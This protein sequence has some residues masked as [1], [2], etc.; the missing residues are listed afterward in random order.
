[1][2][3]CL[4]CEIASGN[5]AGDILYEDEQVVAF[6]DINPKAP[7]HILVIPRRHISTINDL[8][9]GDE[10]VIGKLFTAAKFLAENENIA[11]GGYRV[12]MNCNADGGQ[13][14]YHIHLHL[15]GGRPMLWP[16][17]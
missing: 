11:D 14:V 2:S 4:F 17:G 9:D 8:S 12:V 3:S 16:P 7:V 15:L 5:I 10:T 6:R 1:M 13:S